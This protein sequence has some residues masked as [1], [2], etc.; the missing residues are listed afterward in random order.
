MLEGADLTLECDFYDSAIATK[1]TKDQVDYK[2]F[3]SHFN[4][5]TGLTSTKI[6]IRNASKATDQV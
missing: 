5:T 2:D 4:D 1:W 6:S 3:T